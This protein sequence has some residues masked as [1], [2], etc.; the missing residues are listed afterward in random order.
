MKAEIEDTYVEAF[1]GLFTRLVI[2]AKEAKLLNKASYNS[3][4]LPSIVINRTEGGVERWLHEKETPDGRVG[5][6]VQFWG[7]L[8]EMDVDKSVDRFY[9]EMSYRIRQ[10]ILVVPTTAVFNAYT[11]TEI[12]DTMDRIGH[13]GDGYER[14][15]DYNGRH[16]IKVPLMMG[17]FIIERYIG[18]GEGV[19]GGNIWLMCE[20]EEAALEAGNKAVEA[21]KSVEGVVTPFDICSAGSKPETMYPEIGP[22]TNH[23]YCPTLLNKIPDSK[24]PKGVNSIPEIV[25]NGMTLE[26]VK[27]ALKVAILSSQG[28]KGVVKISAGNYGGRLGKYKIFLRDLFL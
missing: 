21:I 25:I 2:T 23:L 20:S 14:E 8:D 13:C 7:G 5:S 18:Y 1:R 19:M 9:R 6:I 4:A 15:E 28:V 12:I 17:D 27:S 26:A 3:T 11:S 16:V 22:T 24:I 10:G